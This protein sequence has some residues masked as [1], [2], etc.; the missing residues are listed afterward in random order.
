MSL[1]FFIN[2]HFGYVTKTVLMTYQCF[3]C[4]SA[5]LAERQRLLFFPAPLCT[6]N[7]I[8]SLE[9]CSKL[10]GDTSWTADSNW[11]RG[12]STPCNTMLSNKTERRGFAGRQPFA[13]RLAGHHSAYGRWRVIALASLVLS[14]SFLPLLDYPYLDSWVPLLLFLLFSPPSC[15]R[16]LW[17]WW[18][19]SGLAAGQGKLT[20]AS[21]EKLEQHA[22]FAHKFFSLLTILEFI[23]QP[24]SKLHRQRDAALWVSADSTF[25]W[26]RKCTQFLLPGLSLL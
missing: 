21:Q 26:Q 25:I 3:G 15:C 12:Y 2:A 20:T 13:Q 16:G 23:S 8:R 14:S 4:C 19:V 9:V 17:W 18:R 5:V 10:G 1:I 22:M 24:C 11:L 6:P 7:P